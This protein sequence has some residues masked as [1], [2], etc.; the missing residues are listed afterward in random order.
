APVLALLLRALARDTSA[1]AAEYQREQGTI[2]A[3]LSE[4]VGGH[5]TIRAAGAEER[6]AAR[7]LAPLPRLSRAG[8]AM[9][10]VQGRAA[11]QA[12]TVGP[13]LNLGVVAVA[14]LLLAHQRLTV[15]EVLAA[16]RY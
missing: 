2:A 9:W 3:A 6:E 11:A 5:R 10:R 4:A 15:G 7:V 14:G 16:S 1:C 12:L 8:H 13:L